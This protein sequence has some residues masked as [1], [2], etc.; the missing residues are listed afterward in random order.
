MKLKPSH[1]NFP[2]DVTR[3]QN[4]VINHGFEC[5][6]KQADELWRLYSDSLYAGWLLMDAYNETV[7]WKLI[8]E[9]IDVDDN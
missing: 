2:E 4:A 7:I 1:E 9:F 5:S 8:E 6:R 3:V